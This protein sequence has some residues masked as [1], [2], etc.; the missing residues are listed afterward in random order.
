M[1]DV[2]WIY[3]SVEIVEGTLFPFDKLRLVIDTLAFPSNFFF[4]S[5]FPFSPRL[6][7]FGPLFDLL[8]CHRT[9][10]QTLCPLKCYAKPVFLSFVSSAGIYLY[11]IRIRLRFPS[12]LPHIHFPSLMVFVMVLSICS[13]PP[14]TR[15]PPHYP[16]WPFIYLPTYILFFFFTRFRLDVVIATFV[17]KL[18]GETLVWTKFPSPFFFFSFV[19][20]FF[21]SFSQCP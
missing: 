19:C 11:T 1:R 15:I 8:N 10:L 4:S 20:F 9:M 3:A 7:C 21:F 2:L 18:T 5:S 14:S 6:Q 16:L 13:I 12:Y 17:F